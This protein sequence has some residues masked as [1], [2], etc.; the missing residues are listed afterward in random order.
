[1]PGFQSSLARADS[2]VDNAASTNGSRTCGLI[3]ER[4]SAV[5]AFGLGANR[6]LKLA[7]RDLAELSTT[8]LEATGGDYGFTANPNRDTIYLADGKGNSPGEV[9]TIK[10]ISSM[11]LAQIDSITISIAVRHI[12]V[13]PDGSTLAASGGGTSGEA[14][15]VVNLQ[16][17]SSRI[18]PATTSL[19]SIAFSPDG[20]FIYGIGL[21]KTVDG[22]GTLGARVFRVNVA[23]LEVTDVIAFEPST[24]TIQGLA[25]TSQFAYTFLGGSSAKPGYLVQVNLAD[26]KVSK[27][28]ELSVADFSFSYARFRI[29][30]DGS[31]L[32]A[33]AWDQL[34]KI[35]LASFQVVARVKI[36]D[37]I[38]CLDIASSGEFALVT[39][40]NSIRNIRR[41]NLTASEVPTLA[42]DAP[43]A[44]LVNGEPLN[45]LATSDSGL[46]VALTSLTPKMCIISNGRL[47]P[48]A[49]G[50]CVVQATHPNESGWASTSLEKRI[51]ISRSQMGVKSAISTLSL[52]LNAG[53]GRVDRASVTASVDQRSR[54]VCR[55]VKKTLTASAK[56]QCRISIN[57]R[58]ASNKKFSKSMTIRV[59]D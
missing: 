12:A 47:R 50:E 4:D 31:F 58:T 49:V 22:K 37:Q 21:G 14:I 34:L 19:G 18:L 1:M 57:G 59:S 27:R 6:L 13:S 41:V 35:N 33:T 38:Y 40:W 54:A 20:A 9:G 43:S 28:L 32:Y 36:P 5:V 39:T 48:V 56:G 26:G 30:P 46:E 10:V 2:L 7:S 3:M 11:T 44:L 25:I 45:A 29:S 23:T 24:P 17:K 53:A 16:E 55:I 42:I 8:K 15:V 52:A 51:V